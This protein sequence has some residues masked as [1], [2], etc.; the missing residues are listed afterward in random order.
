MQFSSSINLNY[1]GIKNRYSDNASSSQ[2]MTKQMRA[3]YFKQICTILT[4]QKQI[5]NI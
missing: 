3:V 2:Q 4:K 5:F 1:P